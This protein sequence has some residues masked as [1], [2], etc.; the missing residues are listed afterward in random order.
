MK[1]DKSQ[2]LSQVLNTVF[3]SMALLFKEKQPLHIKSIQI[4]QFS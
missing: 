1:N 3:I 2:E 4:C